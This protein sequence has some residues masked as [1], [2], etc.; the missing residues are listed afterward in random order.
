MFSSFRANIFLV[1]AFIIGVVFLSSPAS[2]NHTW[3]NYHWARTS[4]PFTIK[5]GDNVS[6]TWDTYL[7]LA[8][9]DWSLSSV[10]DTT[11][12]TGMT[13]PKNCKPIPGRVE[14][15]NSRYG[16][17]GW[18]GI[19]SVWVNSGHITQGTVKMNDTYFN[20][21]KY[22]KPEWKQ[23]V[24]CQEIGHTFGLDHQDEDHTNANL[25]TCMDYTNDP[26]LNQ[27]PNQHDYDMLDTMYA[28]LDTTSTVASTVSPASVN[29]IDHD[30][31]STWG[32]SIRTSKDGRA[33]LY[34]KE[35]LGGQVFTFVIW[36]E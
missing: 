14:I 4:N 13:N 5:L 9:A 11:V 35:T 33:S 2:A 23:F 22:N 24:M 21:A 30:N 15:C 20:T 8:S 16:N 25:N 29:A 26:L 1:A 10:L 18:L 34:V 17:N 7:T 12:V 31:Q 6:S 19:A 36:A 28:H 3:S 27:L 32:Q